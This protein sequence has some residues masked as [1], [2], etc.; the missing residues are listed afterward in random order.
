MIVGRKKFK[1]KNI[2]RGYDS[3]RKIIDSFL[4]LG[5]KNF[6]KDQKNEN[7]PTFA[8]TPGSN[9]PAEP[10]LSNLHSA[11]NTTNVDSVIP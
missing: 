1:S 2:I 5:L 11:N 8:V 10:G 4:F 7:M 6:F 9:F 3:S